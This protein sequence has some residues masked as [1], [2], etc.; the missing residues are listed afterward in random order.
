MCVCVC[1]SVSVSVY[2]YI[3]AFTCIRVYTCS[4]YICVCLRVLMH[5][6]ICVWMYMYVSVWINVKTC[7]SYAI[8]F[9]LLCLLMDFDYEQ[10]VVICPYWYII[11]VRFYSGF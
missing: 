7:I 4:M 6:N 3:C 1:V 2:A 10:W 8:F 9:L 11:P 5:E